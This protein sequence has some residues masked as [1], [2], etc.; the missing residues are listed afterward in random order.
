[1]TGG[2]GSGAAETAATLFKQIKHMQ[3]VRLQGRACGR[4]QLWKHSRG[5]ATCHWEDWELR[6]GTGHASGM[7]WAGSGLQSDVQTVT[8][9]HLKTPEAGQHERTGSNF[10]EP[11]ACLQE[12]RMTGGTDECCV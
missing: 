3:I 7:M 12:G 6:L 11:T 1:M 8:K 5:A 4:V 9:V 2:P 10:C